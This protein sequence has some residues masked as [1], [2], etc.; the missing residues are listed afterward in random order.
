MKALVANLWGESARTVRTVNQQGETIG[1]TPNT[2]SNENRA[3]FVMRVVD[4]LKSPH[5]AQL[6]ESLVSS[7]SALWKRGS[8]DREDLVS[9]LDVLTQQGMKPEDAPFVAAQQLLLTPPETDNEFRA[10]AEFYEKYPDSVS[11]DQRDTLKAADIEYVGE[12]LGIA[13]EEFTQGLY[14][15]ADEIE[16]ERA[17]QEPPDEDDDGPWRSSESQVDDIQ[18]MFDGLQSDLREK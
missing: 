1:V 7:L 13:T 17:D 10:A 4:D 16:S 5:A 12:K 8:G 18:S 3:A 6:T 15:R 9:L 14:E 2:P 11:G